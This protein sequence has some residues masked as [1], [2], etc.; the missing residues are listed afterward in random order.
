[1]LLLLLLLSEGGCVGVACSAHGGSGGGCGG[2]GCGV[3]HQRLLIRVHHRHAGGGG[4]RHPGGVLLEELHAERRRPGERGVVRRHRG[5]ARPALVLRLRLLLLLL[6]LLPRSLRLLLLLV[7]GLLTAVQRLL[8]LFLC[9]RLLVL[10]LVA[11]LDRP[12]FVVVCVAAA[13]VGQPR[14]VVRRRRLSLRVHRFAQ[15]SRGR[16]SGRVEGATARELPK[17]RRP[18]RRRLRARRPLRRRLR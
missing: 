6:L 3:V 17:S 9:H 4:R 10:L 11:G 13:H 5:V 2:C 18:A 12:A 7:R 15:L 8:L 1:M 14:R 16:R